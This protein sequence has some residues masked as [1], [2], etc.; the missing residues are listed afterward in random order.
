MSKNER[1]RVLKRR[2]DK[3]VKFRDAISKVTIPK[4]PTYQQQKVI[5]WFLKW[6]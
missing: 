4:N 1:L 2:M 3:S 5:S 6:N